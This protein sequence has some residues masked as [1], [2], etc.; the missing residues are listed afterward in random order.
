MTRRSAN[1]TVRP[2]FPTTTPYGANC[3]GDGIH[4]SIFSRNATRVWILLFD[5][6]DD[7]TPAMEIELDPATNRTGDIWH[8]WVGGLRG[9]QLYLWRMDGPW[10]PEKGHRFDKNVYLLDPCAKALTSDFDWKGA[11]ARD[12]ESPLAVRFTGE[13]ARH[14]PKCVAVTDCFY[15]EEDRPLNRPLSETI[16]YECHVRGLTAH[17]SSGVKAP[18]T[19]TG[20]VE[21]IPYFKE[22]GVTALELLPVNEFSTFQKGYRIN[23]ETG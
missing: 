2:G 8:A 9:G 14:M 16:I 7:D 11:T 5:T 19:F 6:P 17:D 13:G 1:V 4:F 3:E 12:E 22:L 23:P 18:G 20:V 21:K 15:W 10:A